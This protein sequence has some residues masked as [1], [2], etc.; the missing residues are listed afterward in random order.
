MHFTDYGDADTPYMSHCHILQYEDQ[1]M[2]GQFLV[3]PT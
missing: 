3:V 1:G 2:V